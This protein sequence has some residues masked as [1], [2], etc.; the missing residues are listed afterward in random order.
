MSQCAHCRRVGPAA[1]AMANTC[2]S[3]ASDD[4]VCPTVPADAGGA[5]AS[6]LPVGTRF[7]RYIVLDWRGAGGMGVVYSAYDP[8]L[9][10]KVALK[11]LRSACGAEDRP[12]LRDLLLREAQAMARLAHPNVVTVF[13]AGSVDE[14]VFIAMELIEGVTLGAWLRRALRTP[15]EILARFLAAGHGLAAAHAAGLMHRDFKP[16]NV[17]LGDDG[18]VCV[19]DFGLARPVTGEQDRTRCDAAERSALTPR[20][21]PAGTLAYM[22]PEQY[23]GRPADAR[24]DQFSFAVALYEALYGAPPFGPRRFADD[25]AGHQVRAAPRGSRVPRAVRHALLRALRAAPEDRYP[26][27]GELLAA[28]APDRPSRRSRRLGV[29]AVAAAAAVLVGGGVYAA[30]LRDAAEHRAELAGRL[31]GM[32]PELRTLLRSAHMLPIHDIRAARARVQRAMHDVEAQLQTAA[33]QDL[34]ALGDFVLGEGYRALGDDD[35]ALPRF[36]AAWAAGER[37]PDSDAALGDTLGAVYE[38]R[39]KELEATAPPERRD[40]RLHALETRYRDPALAHLRAAIAARTGSPAYL[41]ALIAFH[42]RRFDDAR[43]DAA[44]ALAEAPTFYEAGA[45]EARARDEIGHELWT[46][47]KD[48][49]ARREFAAARRIFGH[50]LEI[51]RSDDA[52]WLGYAAM[53]YGQALALARGGAMPPELAQDALTALHNAAQIDPEN[54]RPPL[55]EAE[56]QLGQG[57]IELY[58]YRDP[59]RYVDAALVL[60]DRARTLAADAAEVEDLTCQAYWERTQYQGGHGIDPGPAYARATAACARAVAA[61]PDL[62]TYSSLGVLYLSWGGYQSAHGEPA[63]RSFEHAERSLAAAVA[64]SDDP[65]I[66]YDLGVLWTTVARDHVRHGRNPDAAVERALAEYGITLKQSPRRADAWTG[67]AHAQLERARFRQRAHQDVR[68]ALAAARAA[69]EHAL[70]IHPGFTQAIRYQIEVGELEVEVLLGRGADPASVLAQLRTD[71]AWLLARI[72]AEGM[73]H[74]LA[75]RAELAAARQARA[76]HEP[77]A[78]FLA[79]AAAESARARDLDPL[80]ALAWATSAEVEQLCAE[81]ACGRDADPSAAAERARGFL[82]HALAID[83]GDVPIRDVHDALAGGTGDAAR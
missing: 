73:A 11:V 29:A 57:N 30:H 32:A 59:G 51:A 45:L 1:G 13:D 37:G 24:A 39:V 25:A 42:H 43:R 44:T 70:A 16:D 78:A 36:E 49:P 62:E 31:R 53:V 17:L 50:V 22:A 41:Q 15:R 82:E 48:D 21:R 8:E 18:R 81:A 54:A 4:S 77:A 76:R 6:E 20:A 33:G 40:D 66:H 69:C 23:L 28:L 79:S 5:A 67:T 71:A 64:I 46:A 26:S 55:R 56:I 12:A 68:D 27:I 75:A 58:G 14:R 80:D 63:A 10:R 34:R 65:G 38:A 2:S 7:G 35:R 47:G 74:R 19:T 61:R 9:N 83:P 60:T 3:P 72:P 52:M